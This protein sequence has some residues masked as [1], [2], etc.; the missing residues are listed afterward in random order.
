MKHEKCAE[1]RQKLPSIDRHNLPTRL[2]VALL[3][4][5]ENI[6]EEHENYCHNSVRVLAPQAAMVAAQMAITQIDEAIRII[7]GLSIA[8][9]DPDWMKRY[10]EERLPPEAQAQDKDTDWEEYDAKRS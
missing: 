7:M 9:P 3:A 2:V 4:A 6:T 1:L 8:E 10:N 5:S